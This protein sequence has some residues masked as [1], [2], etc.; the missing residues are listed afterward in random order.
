MVFYR[1]I[2][3]AQIFTPDYIQLLFSNLEEM[4]HIHS[5]FNNL[6]KVKRRDSPMVGDIADILLSMVSVFVCGGGERERERENN[7]KNSQWYMETCISVGR[8][9]H[10]SETRYLHV[11][12]KVFMVM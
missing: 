12:E 4:L 9:Q 8:Y 3:D 6:L 10:L 1:P 7:N 5:Q 11:Y 2:L